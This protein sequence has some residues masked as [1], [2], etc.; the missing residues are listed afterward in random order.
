MLSEI[1]NAHRTDYAPP[2]KNVFPAATDFSKRQRKE[3]QQLTRNKSNN[4]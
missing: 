1:G 3:H 4:V 2:G